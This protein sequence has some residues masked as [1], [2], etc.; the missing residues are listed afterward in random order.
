MW[1]IFF[2]VWLTIKELGRVEEAYQISLF[3]S[4]QE[5]ICYKYE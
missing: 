5:V 3:L 4:E 2:L 1:S